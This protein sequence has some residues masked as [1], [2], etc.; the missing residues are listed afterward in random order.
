K[1]EE[2]RNF[3]QERDE[4]LDHAWE[5]YNDLIYQCLLHDLNCQQKVHIFYTGSYLNWQTIR[6][7]R[8]LKEQMGSPYR[9]RE[10][11]RMIENPEEIHKAKAQDDKRDMDVGWDIMSKDVE[12]LR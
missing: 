11:V 6:M 8:H 7:T 3:K 9:S 4:T 10:T 1:L 5:R 12:R 2:I